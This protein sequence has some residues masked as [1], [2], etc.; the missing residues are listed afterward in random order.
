MR[1]LL[2]ALGRRGPVVVV[3]DDVHWADPALVDV[4]DHLADWVRDAASCWCASSRP[5]L[6]DARPTWGGGRVN[7]TSLLLSPL[8]PGRHGGP[9]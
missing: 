4:L 1:R 5:E 9:A 3:V 2:E 8:A 7:A 6:L